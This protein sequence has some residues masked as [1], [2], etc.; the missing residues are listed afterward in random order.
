MT[1]NH[2]TP[3]SEATLEQ[4][5]ARVAAL[6][7]DVAYLRQELDDARVLNRIVAAVAD[8][9]E[10]S[11]A[12]TGVCTA[13]ASAYDVPQ[14]ALAVLDREQACLHVVAEYCA[15]G[16]PQG[17]GERIPLIGNPIID[18]VSAH[19]M[20]LA[21]EDVSTDVRVVQVRDL[22][23]RRGTRSI[24]IAPIFVQDELIGTVGLDAIE[25]RVFRERDI[26]LAQHVSGAISQ[27]L[28]NVRLY[29]AVQREL[30]E[31][32][33]AEA[34]IQEQAA[35][36]ALLSTPL[37]P[38]TD[39]VLILPLIGELDT[40]RARQVLS[41][42]LDGVARQRAASIII[43][44]TGMPMVDTQVASALLQAAQAVQLLGAETII[45]GVRPEIAQTLVSLGVEMRGIRTF[46]TLQSAV[47]HA[48]RRG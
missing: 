37:I 38:I 22:F 48:I 47:K 29:E 11:T 13:L 20:P 23:A 36:L 41:T 45:T 43:D 10:L 34:V 27:G 24:L 46:S 39:R 40:T 6:E 3:S 5:L 12:F 42:L 44:I 1:A 8:A 33:R 30:T 4:S 18:Y 32:R 35:M 19:R 21:I 2:H 14:V 17:L 7:A 26:N 31:R 25:P 15:P 9:R 16:R 28:Y